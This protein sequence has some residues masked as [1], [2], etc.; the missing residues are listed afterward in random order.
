MNEL[1]WYDAALHTLLVLTTIG[2]CYVIWVIVKKSPKSMS[3][4]R[5]LL[6]L[7]TFWDMTFTIVVGGVVRPNPIFPARAVNVAGLGSVFGGELGARISIHLAGQTGA[8]VILALDYCLIYRMVVILEDQRY[9]RMFVTKPAYVGFQSFGVFVSVA[10]GVVMYHGFITE[11]EE[12]VRLVAKYPES[13]WLLR[14]GLPVAALDYEKTW[15]LIA[16]SCIFFAVSFGVVYMILRTLRA[17]SASFS[18]KTY[19]MHMQL[20]AL[21]LVQVGF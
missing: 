4:Y 10:V 2:Q 7:C 19:R 9:Y 11:R 12:A 17:H 16:F 6:C 13:L 8:A 1:T 15:V 20:T 21:L 14:P 18:A 3:E 5:Y